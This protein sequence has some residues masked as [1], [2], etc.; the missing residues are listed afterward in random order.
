VRLPPH[1]PFTPSAPVTSAGAFAGRDQELK[2]GLRLIQQISGANAQHGLIT[3]ARGIGK[4]SLAMAMEGIARGEPD[5]LRLVELPVDIRWRPL[6]VIGHV[7]QRPQSVQDVATGLARALDQATT[8]S[9]GLGL[10]DVQIDL[11]IAKFKLGPKSPVTSDDPAA[12]LIDLVESA[13]TPVLGR[14]AGMMA[15]VDEVDRIADAPGMA[16][17]L[18]VSSELLV[19][20]KLRNVGFV[21]VGTEGVMEALLKDHASVDRVFEVIEVPPLTRTEVGDLFEK[22]LFGTGVTVSPQAVRLV[23]QASGGLPFRVQ[24]LGYE[25]FTRVQDSQAGQITVAIARKAIERL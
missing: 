10:S 8:A 3:G 24:R 19:R 9:S 6:M 14:Y 11:R 22:T 2:A 13:L 5:Y 25:A 15:F 21:L 16:S 12:N 17:F 20:R 4:S 23:H 1:N 7:A 18:K